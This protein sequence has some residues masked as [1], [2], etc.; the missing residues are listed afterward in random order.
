MCCCCC[1]WSWDF[2]QNA[3]TGGLNAK[4]LFNQKEFPFTD[5]T[6]TT[7]NIYAILNQKRDLEQKVDSMQCFMCNKNQKTMIKFMATQHIQKKTPPKIDGLV[8]HLSFFW[9]RFGERIQGHL[10]VTIGNDNYESL[11]TE[12]D[13]N[14]LLAGTNEALKSRVQTTKK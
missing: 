7:N 6:F 1:S 3:H 11:T 12:N 14:R 8:V 9:K 2:A 13:K 10:T 4:H 5:L